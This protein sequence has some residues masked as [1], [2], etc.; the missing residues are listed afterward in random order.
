MTATYWGLLGSTLAVLIEFSFKKLPGGY[1]MWA[2]LWVP[3]GVAVNYIVYRLLTSPGTSMIDAFI[4]W[5]F[6]TILL[7]LALSVFVLQE[8]ITPGTWAALGLLIV[9]RV[10]QLYW[11]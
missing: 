9:A 7:R 2:W 5:T 4:I 1:M 10:L 3:G 6:S 8:Y 11:K